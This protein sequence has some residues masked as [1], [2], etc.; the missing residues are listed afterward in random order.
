R[1]VQ[2][3]RRYRVDRVVAIA[4]RVADEQAMLDSARYDGGSENFIAPVAVAGSLTSSVALL[5]RAKFAFCPV[6]PP[7]EVSPLA[8]PT[9]MV[10]GS[11]PCSSDAV[12]NET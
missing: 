8:T 6:T 7:Y 2:R 3:P 12:K 11:E 4:G 10:T 9:A 5:S 1:P